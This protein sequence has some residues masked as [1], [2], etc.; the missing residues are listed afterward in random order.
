MGKTQSGAVFTAEIAGVVA[1]TDIGFSFEVSGSE[2]WLGLSSHH[3]Y[4]FQAGDLKLASNVAFDK[5]EEA[6]VGGGMMGA[7]I[8]V[9]EVYAH[10]ARDLMEGSYTTPGFDHAL[11]NARLIEAVARRRSG[12]APETGLGPVLINRSR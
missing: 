8:N 7:A 4:G 9:G 6:V 2:G 10:L 5:P 11:H 12:H 1:P 3:P